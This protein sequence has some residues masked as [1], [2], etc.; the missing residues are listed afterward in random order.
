MRNNTIAII[1]IAVIAVVASGCAAR[2]QV[3]T[4]PEVQH[5]EVEEEVEIVQITVY[6]ESLEDAE[7]QVADAG[8]ELQGNL[9]SARALAGDNPLVPQWR[10][11]A[12]IGEVRAR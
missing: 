3:T 7:Q 4:I 1:A 12:Y 9:Q 2:P 11:D 10:Q 5:A 6:A 8:F